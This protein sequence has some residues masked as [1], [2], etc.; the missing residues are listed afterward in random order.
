MIHTYIDNG[1]NPTPPDVQPRPVQQT[2]TSPHTAPLN[3][4]NPSITLTIKTL[5]T[6]TTNYSQH[7]NANMPINITIWDQPSVQYQNPN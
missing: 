7:S 5:S 4:D 2:N 3:K 6:I 1:P